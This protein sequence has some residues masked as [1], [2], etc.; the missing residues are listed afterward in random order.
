MRVPSLAWSECLL[1]MLRLQR[2]PTHFMGDISGLPC[3]SSLAIRALLQKTVGFEYYF[4]C[5]THAGSW[6]LPDRRVYNIMEEHN[7]RTGTL[8]APFINAKLNRIVNF[9]LH[10]CCYI[11][12]LV[13]LHSYLEVSYRSVMTAVNFLDRW[14]KKSQ[15]FRALLKLAWA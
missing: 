1:C 14:R 4:V 5:R 11:M 7:F 8:T 13:S 9:E 15:R 3:L 12:I 2:L 10:A 6:R